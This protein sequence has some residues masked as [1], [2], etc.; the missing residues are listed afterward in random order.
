MIRSLAIPAFF[1]LSCCAMAASY[2]YKVLA[3]SRTSTMEKELNEAAGAGYIFQDVMAGKTSAGGKEVVVIMVKN[4]AGD[5]APKRSYKLLATSRTS[6]MQK[7]LQQLGDQGYEYKGQTVFD[8][9][10]VIMER[11]GAAAKRI[12]Y[13]LLATS[14][15]STMEKELKDA[16]AAGFRLAGL[17]VASTTFGGAEVLSILWKD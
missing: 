10:V 13:K 14:R 16:G 15:T 17:T 1:A 6:T 7:E 9:V 4:P 8:E 11:T 5:S 3:T 12:E 2:D